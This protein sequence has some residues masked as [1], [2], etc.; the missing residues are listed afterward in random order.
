MKKL[1]L[2]VVI[3]ALGQATVF[4]QKEVSVKESAVPV[5]YVKDFN[6][7]AKDAQSA[8]W[9]MVADSSAYMVTFTNSDGDRQSIRFTSKSTEKRYYV[10]SQYYPHAILDT[11]ANSYPK[12]KIKNLYIRDLKGKMTYQC[13]IA[14]M[15][16]ILFWR[17]EASAKLLSFETNGKMIEVIDE[18]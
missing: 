9:T 1:F 15:K 17:K 8:A 7:Q 4:A 6:N 11:V 18:Q 16:G 10:E 12:Y 2:F 5:R 13:R 14:K 3:L